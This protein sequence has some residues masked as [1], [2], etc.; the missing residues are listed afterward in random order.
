MERAEFLRKQA[1]RFL[2]PAKECADPKVQAE[3]VRMANEYI[4]LLK[5]RGPSGPPRP[6]QEPTIAE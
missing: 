4:E 2:L 5:N 1:E 3:L 6:I